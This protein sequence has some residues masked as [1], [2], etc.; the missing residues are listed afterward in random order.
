MYSDYKR[1][2]QYFNKNSNGSIIQA[3]P[4]K[5]ENSEY[6]CKNGAT[7]ENTNADKES[8]SLFGFKCVCPPGYYGEY[9]EKSKNNTISL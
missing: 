1:H 6:L 3:K 4:L 2:F 9:C 5:C 7:C 8:T